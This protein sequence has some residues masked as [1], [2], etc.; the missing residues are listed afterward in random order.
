M[1]LRC[2]LFSSDERT[3]ERICQVLPS[4]GLQGEY[5][6]D[7]K[8]AVEK[9]S[10]QIFQIVI[11]DWDRQPEAVHLLSTACQRK[12]AER[13]LTLAIV[14]DDLSVPKALQAGAN[15]ILRKPILITQVTDTLKTGSELVP[16]TQQAAPSVAHA[17]AAGVS[18]S[19]SAT[20]TAGPRSGEATQPR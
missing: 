14:S 10:H 13:P 4:L 6:S 9:V 2:L 18:A 11:I 12:A 8:A 15:S 7:A 17:A 19:S 16:A 20:P 1:A 5:C 3:A